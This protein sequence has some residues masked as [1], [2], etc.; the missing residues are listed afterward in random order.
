MAMHSLRRPTAAA[1]AAVL[2]LGLGALAGCGG[3][4]GSDGT[5]SG[6]G[7]DTTVTSEGATTA[8][9]SGDTTTAPD[10]ATTTAAEADG[11]GDLVG[12]WTA[13]AGDIFGANTAN[14][15]G[16]SIDCSGPVNLEFRDD[17]TFS[18]SSTAT[19]SIQSI[20]GTATIDSTGS[21][22]TD[23]DQIV[24]SGSTSD[25]TMEIMGQTQPVEAGMSDG[26]A[27]YEVDGDTLSITFTEATVGTVTQVYQRA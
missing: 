14:L 18:Q 9:P 25:G 2:A 26:T 6:S 23:G 20:S 1:L 8:A 11:G 13:D 24:I 15:G 17:G 16:T 4:S 10:E 22:T 19:C 12:T 27:T 7:S 3:S 21:W 5:G